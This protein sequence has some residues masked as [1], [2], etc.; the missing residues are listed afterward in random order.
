[1]DIYIYIIPYLIFI[2]DFP[3]CGSRPEVWRPL[4][5]LRRVDI[6]FF[7]SFTLTMERR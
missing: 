1:M 4:L 6:N 7:P 5:D 2:N 3:D